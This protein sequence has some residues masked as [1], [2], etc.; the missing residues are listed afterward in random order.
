MFAL[1]FK[2]AKNTKSLTIV[3][4]KIDKLD[5]AKEQNTL[6]SVNKTANDVLG[7]ILGKNINLVE[8]VPCTLIRNKNGEKSAN[9]VLL[10]VIESYYNTKRLV[11]K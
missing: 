5:K 8:I 10:A 4:N 6:E 11:P 2:L 1:D 3:L 9:E 7:N